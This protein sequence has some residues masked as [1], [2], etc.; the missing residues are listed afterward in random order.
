MIEIPEPVGIVR[1]IDIVIVNAIVKVI[2]ILDGLEILLENSNGNRIAKW[3]ENDNSNRNSKSN[4]NSDSNS[5]RY[6][7]A[8]RDR[9]CNKVVKRILIA[10]GIATAIGITKYWRRCAAKAIVNAN[11]KTKLK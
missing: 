9:N 6:C 1:V 11:S 8:S 2:G 4:S 5:S 10:I 7:N 3:N